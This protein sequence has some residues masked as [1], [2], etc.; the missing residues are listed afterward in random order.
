LQQLFDSKEAA[1]LILSIEPLR[2]RIAVKLQEQLS[3]STRELLKLK[4][5]LMISD[6]K[7]KY[8]EK[9]FN[10][11]KQGRIYAIRKLRGK[12]NDAMDILPTESGQ[13]ATLNIINIIK[14]MIRREKPAD[15]KLTLKFAFD[16]C[17]ITANIEEVIGTISNVHMDK[18]SKSPK[19]ADQFVV[20]IGSESHEEYNRELSTVKDIINGLLANPNIDVDG[21]TY[22]L[23][24]Y[25][26]LDM[27]SLCVMLGLY[28][29]YRSNCN[30]RCCWC[31]VQKDDLGNFTHT[32]WPLR[33][34][35]QMKD[36]SQ[37]GKDPGQNFGIK[38]S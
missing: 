25:L 36:L 19:N 10:L 35:Q 37:N 22:T 15:K 32:H 26:V 1:E 6:H 24:P 21:E 9:T 18:T 3:P 38:V 31:N 8:F 16:A 11:G 17:R 20:W 23:D 12:L 28:E 4:D 33:M 30:Y 2:E 34:I 27:K 14:N 13:G 7:W 29:V 5:W